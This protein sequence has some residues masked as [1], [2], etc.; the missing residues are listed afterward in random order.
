MRTNK[1]KCTQG[2]WEVERTNNDFNGNT[3]V[4][5]ISKEDE[6]E[7]N[8]NIVAAA[9]NLLKA[10]ERCKI[11]LSACKKKT[12]PVGFIESVENALKKARGDK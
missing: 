10:L 12:F 7:G 9:P 1:I 2:P 4:K 3:Y 6:I 5:I 8:I 11:Y